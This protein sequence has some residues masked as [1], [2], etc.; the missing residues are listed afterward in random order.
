MAVREVEITERDTRIALLEQQLA[1]ARRQQNLA[2]AS[3]VPAAPNSGSNLMDLLADPPQENISQRVVP[4]DQNMDAFDLFEGHNPPPTQTPDVRARPFGSPQDTSAPLQEVAN[5]MVVKA[6]TWAT[7]R[8]SVGQ[9]SHEVAPNVVPSMPQSFHPPGIAPVPV[10]ASPQPAELT[11]ANLP[12][13]TNVMV[14]SANV[15]SVSNPTESALVQ[16]L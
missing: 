15:A 4:D 1:E 14:P 12:M 3:L 8:V 6:T 11:V 9:S 7:P 5:P 13:P 10:V 16:Q 2:V